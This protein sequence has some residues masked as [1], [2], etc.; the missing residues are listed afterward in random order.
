MGID[1]S[2]QQPIFPNVISDGNKNVDVERRTTALGVWHT[3][4]S[5]LHF[6]TVNRAR[7]L[8]AMPHKP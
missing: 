6:Y 2:R 3:T 5:K 4:V 7:T 1:L 8:R